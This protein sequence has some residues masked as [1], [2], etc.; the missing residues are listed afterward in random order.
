MNAEVRYMPEAEDY[1]LVEVP[2]RKVEIKITLEDVL[3]ALGEQAARI[4]QTVQQ[5][6]SLNRLSQLSNQI[7][8]E[9]SQL[10]SSIRERLQRGRSG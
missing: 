10:D 1:E 4:A 3:D 5:N 9:V 6:E 7:S 8:G 2:V